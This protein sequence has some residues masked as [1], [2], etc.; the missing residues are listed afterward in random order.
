MADYV[1][2]SYILEAYL[3]YRLLEI[4]VIEHFQRIAVYE[5]HSV[6]FDLGMA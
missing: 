1:V 2:E 4:I 5:K 6:T 3:F